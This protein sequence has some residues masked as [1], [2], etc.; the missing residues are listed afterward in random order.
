[1]ILPTLFAAKTKEKNLDRKAHN[2]KRIVLQPKS[3]R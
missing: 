3:Q 2:V 1:M